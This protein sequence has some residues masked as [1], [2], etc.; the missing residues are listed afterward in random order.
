MPLEDY[1]HWNEEAPMIWWQ[2][3]GKHESEPR[4]IDDWDS[5][6][7]IDPCADCDCEEECL[8]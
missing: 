3:E 1:S 4:E 2:E 8:G 6:R 7:E 5:D